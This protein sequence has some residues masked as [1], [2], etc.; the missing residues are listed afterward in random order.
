MTETVLDTAHAAMEAGGDAERMRFFERLADAELFVLLAADPVGEDVT[1]EVFEV[2]DGSFILIFDREDRLSAFVGQPAPYAALSGRAIAAM[3]VGQGIGLGL[4][5][6]VAPSSILIPAAAVDWLTE[7]LGN[8][9]AEVD[10]RPIEIAA[11]H[12]LPEALLSGLDAKLAMVQGVARM[13]Y[14]ASVT[15]APAR[16]GHLLA[17]IDAAP[18]AENALA[19]A[20]GEALTFSGLDA[21]ELDV[22]F[23]DAS[24]PV[25]AKLAKVGLRFDLP[26]LASATLQPAAPGMDPDK[27]PKL[28]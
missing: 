10:A 24:D 12:G 20:V 23:F 6:D 2:A 15:Y 1:P 19:G 7:T 8:R 16:P 25:A 27:P 28:R 4:N 14:L 3:L 13:A 11:P 21:G 17:F 9:P 22:G 18:G 26:E 5:L